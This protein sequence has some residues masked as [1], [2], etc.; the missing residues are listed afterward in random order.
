M[1]QPSSLEPLLSILKDRLPSILQKFNVQFAYLGGS[2]VRHQNAPWSDIDIFA[3]WPGCE[4]T[5]PKELLAQWIELN[6]EAAAA[7]NF[8]AIEITFLERVPL[9]VQFNVIAEGILLFEISEEVRTRFIEHVL[10]VY[11]DHMIWF[12]NYLHQAMGKL[13][14]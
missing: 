4:S 14:Q 8:D 1:M 10:Q 7:T 9:H 2:W 12:K 3:S 5:T 13:L 6:S 11:P